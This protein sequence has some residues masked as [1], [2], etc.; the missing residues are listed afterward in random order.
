MRTLDL[1][2][3]HA[4][5]LVAL[6]RELHQIPEIGLHL[7][8]TQKLVL[9]ALDGLDLEVT[10]GE[11]LSSVVAV[12]RGTAP[13]G[14]DRQVVLL[15]GDMDALPVTEEVDVPYRSRH[16]GQMHACGHDLHT[17]ALVGAA[18]ILSEL[19]DELAGDVVF[20]FQPA[21]E[22][23]GGAAPMIAEGLLEIAGR[24]VD[25]AYAL[26]VTSSEYPLGQWFARPRE[27]MAAV[28]RVSIRMRGAGGHGSQPHRAMDPVP[29]L[30]E[31]VL[32]LQTMVTRSFDAFDSVVLTVGKIAAGTADNI[33]PDTARLEATLRTFSAETRETAVAAIARV[34]NG[35]ASAH[36]LTAEVGFSE[37]YPATINDDAEYALAVETVADMFGADRFSEMPRPEMGSEDMSFVM[38][39][40]PGAYVFISA[41]PAED[42]EAA[43]DNHSPRAA[44]DD[45]VVP[46]AAAWL[47]EV[48]VRRLR[49]GR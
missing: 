10:T 32:A 12:L 40:V 1:A 13:S 20:M 39:K 5:E 23:P 2:K 41:C 37:S 30:C 7:P 38:E 8:L 6:R 47:A 33:I 45:S 19:R 16:E 36:G 31:V 35:V 44:F 46:D 26:H 18:R 15:R 42:H 28:D 11:A 34:A 21:E 22:G 27:M 14:E 25:A 9:E 17:A 29:A 43:P 48:A 49:R 3:N 24:P 4:P